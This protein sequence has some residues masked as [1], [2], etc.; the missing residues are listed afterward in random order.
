MK[1]HPKFL[2]LTA[3]IFS[4]H[5][6]FAQD[7]PSVSYPKFDTS[8]NSK[9][10]LVVSA[11]FRPRTEFKYGYRSLKPF[12]DTG[13]AVYTSSRIRLNFA[14]STK[15]FDF[16]TSLQN[17][18]VWGQNDPRALNGATNSYFQ[19]FE[20]FA[21]PHFTDQFSMR[22]G[23]QRIAYDNQRLFSENDWRQ[24]GNS[25][26]A[27]RLIYNNK[28]DFTTE[29]WTSFNQTAEN[30]FTTNYK[31]VGFNNYK[32]LTVHYLDWNL[33]KHFNFLTINA[34]DGFQA[35]SAARYKTTNMRFTSGG[36]LEFTSYSWYA[37]MSGYYQ[38]GK[39]SSGRKLDAYYMQPEIKFS[40][41]KNLAIRAGFEYMSGQDSSKPVTKDNSFVPLYGTTHKF[42]GNLDYFTTFPVDVAGAG[43][44]DYY[45]FF[46]YLKNK[47]TLR[48]ENHLFYSQNNYRYA[49]S[50]I[51][52]YLGYEQDWKLNYKPTN[53]ADVEF[54]F[55]WAS[56]TKELAIIKK[57]SSGFIGDEKKFPYWTYLSVRFTPTIGK[58]NF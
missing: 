30:T 5:L 43:L 47:F 4:V 29:L 40:G 27:F 45:L 17:V 56:P 34:A 6:L 7:K 41:I 24:T 50:I 55:C 31:P 13:A 16:Y 48:E 54:G 22:I 11:E 21:E 23:R 25:F 38:Y 46:Q 42:M 36:R 12:S 57:P 28:R 1:V 9:S 49:G 53:F 18:Y 44:K 2:C 35:A 37:T 58:F 32:T 39:D 33:S 19:V 20:I 51:N 15:K 14:Y 10:Q 3:A 26:D 52:K 8:K